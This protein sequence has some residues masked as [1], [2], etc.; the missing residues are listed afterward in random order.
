M[1]R[2]SPRKAVPSG[3]VGI[4]GQQTG[5]YSMVSPGGWNLIGRTPRA[6][7]DITRPEPSLLATGDR[8]RFFPI[9]RAEF[10][11]WHE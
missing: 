2:S 9:S 10:D 5:V 7:F 8:V 4:G 3:T 11:S 6:V 1:P